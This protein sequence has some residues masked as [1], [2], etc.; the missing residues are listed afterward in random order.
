MVSV[1]YPVAVVLQQNTTHKN[2][3]IAQN[4][5]PRSNKT[6]NNKAT[7]TIKDTLH[8]MNTTHKKVTGHGGLWGCGVPTP[9]GRGNENSR[10]GRREE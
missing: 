2:T 9:Y 3:H 8:T 7:Q 4:N 5:T 6:Q 1:T 10:E